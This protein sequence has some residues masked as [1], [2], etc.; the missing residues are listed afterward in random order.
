MK[1]MQSVLRS[2]GTG[3]GCPFFYQLVQ[4]SLVK[5]AYTVK[6]S[7]RPTIIRKEKTQWAQEGKT[8]KE[9]STPIP[10]IPIPILPSVKIVDETVVIKSC[11]A[12]DI[13]IEPIVKVIR[14]MPIKPQIDDSTSL[15]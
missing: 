12:K 15:E 1:L 10:P 11:P 5:S 8:E 3:V 2:K 4:K 6:S 7:K 9:K 14:Y 13:T